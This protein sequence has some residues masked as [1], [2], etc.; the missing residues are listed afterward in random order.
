MEEMAFP[1]GVVGPVDFEC[2]ASVVMISPFQKIKAGFLGLPDSI[3][4][5]W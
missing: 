2:G 4:S 3:N 5:G 1:A